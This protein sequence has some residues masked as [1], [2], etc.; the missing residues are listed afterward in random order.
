MRSD[1][2]YVVFDKIDNRLRT[3][4]SVVL[5]WIAFAFQLATRS[6]LAGLPFIIGCVILNFMR[7]FSVKK[8]SS[9]KLEWQEVTPAKI[10]QVSD[11][12]A[13]VRKFRSMG[14]GCA[15][16]LVA[17][18]FFFFIVC[19]PVIAEI[20][21]PSFILYV[22]VINSVILFGGLLIG[23]QKS[24]WMPNSLDVKIEIVRRLT[25][26]QI[27][28]SDPWLIPACFLEIGTAEEGSY[29]NDTRF[30]I[31]FRD[32]PAD[33]VGLQGQVSLNSV[34]SAV[35]PYFYIV[36]IAK[37][38]FN[39]FDKVG[40]PVFPRLVVERKE[41]EGV[42]VI[43][44]RQQTT[45]TSGYHTDAKAQEYITKSGIELAKVILKA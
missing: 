27:V 43:V 45:K 38:G 1:S 22:L 5:I 28:K 20:V 4:M 42:D 2:V 9:T 41:T 34:K 25:S 7:G 24:A 29:P 23:G 39:L 36:I 44:L 21:R 12:C 32:A 13:R 6:I 15:I 16:G 19:A 35:Y 17:G 31:R 37:H 33:F 11:H 3:V 18:A 10:D 40:E 14:T 8:V 26:S 30:M